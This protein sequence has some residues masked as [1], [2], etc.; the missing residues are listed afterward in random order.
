MKQKKSL[1]QLKR[2]L[3]VGTPIEQ[4]AVS[5]SIGAK[6]L[7][8]QRYVV[9]VQGNGVYISESKDAETGSFLGFPPAKLLDY[10][11]DIFTIY[12]VGRR[13]LTDEEIYVLEN[14]PSKREEYREQVIADALS[15]GSM[16][17]NMDK[18]YYK[19]ANKSYLWE[20]MLENGEYVIADPNVRGERVFSYKIG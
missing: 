10:R 9:K 4:V 1:A 19:N 2:D 5:L 17:Y 6:N 20:A 18:A 11:G 3:Q 8:V 14:R 15:D 7:G 16:M 12:S 13:K